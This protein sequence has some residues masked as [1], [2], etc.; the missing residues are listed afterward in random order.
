MESKCKENLTITVLKLFENESRLFNGTYSR[1]WA[2][3]IQK[4]IE[5]AENHELR[6]AETLL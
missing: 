4:F 5:L 3:N 2:M 6:Y 1:S